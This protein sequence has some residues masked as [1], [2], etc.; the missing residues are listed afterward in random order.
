MSEG[1][2]KTIGDLFE[3]LARTP[4][5]FELPD[6]L[7]PEE[8]L[9]SSPV[10]PKEILKKPPGLF[11]A[12]SQRGGFRRS[13]LLFVGGTIAAVFLAV[14]GGS[15]FFDPSNGPLVEEE[16][17]SAQARDQSLKGLV[18]EVQG[19][20]HRSFDRDGKTH[21]QR[22]FQGESVQ[23]GDRILTKGGES[24]EILLADGI[25]VQVRENSNLTIDRFQ[26]SDGEDG[27]RIALTVS[28]GSFLGTIE[29]MKS[30]DEIQFFSPSAVAGVRGTAF[31]MS[32]EGSQTRVT[33]I[34]G[35]VAVKKPDSRSYLSGVWV[36]SSVVVSAGYSTSISAEEHAP[37]QPQK[38][39]E[40]ELRR[41]K[42]KVAHLQ[43]KVDRSERQ[44]L[45]RIN[46]I[47]VV[48]DEKEI[49][50]IYNRGV[51]Q[52]ILRDGRVFTGVVAA[53]DG[54]RLIIHSTGGIHTVNS[55][56]VREIRFL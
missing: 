34:E 5:T 48:T 33:T 39:G 31:V 47:E 56:E 32:V 19:M 16:R 22:M 43:K 20:P 1:K 27:R 44:L 3:Q 25:I 10:D 17:T 46:Q 40:E 4:P 28:N 52:I 54:N 13:G 9:P 50:R 49:E 30:S 8:R 23:S 51:E 26:L 14:A 18:L 24:V 37:L 35:A 45:D 7:D 2:R 53:Q 6:F 55:R 29:K 21:N 42:K 36:N 15:I 11:L 38:V 12:K 41:Q